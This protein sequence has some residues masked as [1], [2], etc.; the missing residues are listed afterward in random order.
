MTGLPNDPEW[1]QN[2]T[3]YV[4]RRLS[5]VGMGLRLEHRATLLVDALVYLKE[6]LDAL[7]GN[8][9][10]LYGT[11]FDGPME[12]FDNFYPVNR[13]IDATTLYAH[14]CLLSSFPGQPFGLDLAATE[15]III[16]NV[17]VCVKGDDGGTGSD[18]GGGGG[19]GAPGLAGGYG[20]PTDGGAG[21]G[22][23]ETTM[24]GYT[25]Y[26]PR[27]SGGDGG[28]ATGVGAGT[29]GIGGL[30]GENSLRYLLWE[31][32]VY[33][34]KLP[35]PSAIGGA[36]G[37][38]GA[39]DG[40]FAGGDGGAGGGGGGVLCLRSPSVS[41]RGE[42]LLTVR[43]GVGGNGANGTGGDAGGGGGG[44]GGHGGIFL[45]IGETFDW[46]SAFIEVNGGDGGEGGAGS[47]VGV[48]GSPGATGDFGMMFWYR[49][50][51]RQ[52]TN[53]D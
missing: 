16:D 7:E 4:R 6:Q 24:S 47:G 51:T 48:A 9:N 11:G 33:R 20:T 35:F 40:T 52:L 50:S 39:G 3:D 18:V 19:G 17:T 10:I 23:S 2:L 42:S 8:P 25:D 45:Y 43:G 22:G 49:P 44:G 36:G 37:G 12:Y 21:A 32:L 15:S 31:A 27:A 38:A 1:I 41:L 26:S 14:E 13:P 30:D 34:Q 29:R 46:V 5:R 53:L 28:A